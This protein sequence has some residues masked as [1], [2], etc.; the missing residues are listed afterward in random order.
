MALDLANWAIQTKAE[1]FA[2]PVLAHFDDV[3][4]RRIQLR[5]K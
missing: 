4:R 5:R 3:T 2:A 1:V